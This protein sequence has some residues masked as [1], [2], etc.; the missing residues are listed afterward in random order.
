[1]TRLH[2]IA[3]QNVVLETL[4]RMESDAE[5]AREQALRRAEDAVRRLHLRAALG[6]YLEAWSAHMA[7]AAARRRAEPIE[8]VLRERD[9]ERLSS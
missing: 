9:A 3:Y 7:A 8:R 5:S 6:A 1:M 2:S 4:L